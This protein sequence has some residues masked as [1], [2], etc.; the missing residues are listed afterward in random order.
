MA[1]RCLPVTLLLL[2]A[3]VLGGATALAPVCLAP[4]ADDG[5]DENCPPACARCTSCAH[6]QTV[7][8]QGET[9]G[10]FLRS[11]PRF[12]P[13]QPASACSR[14]AGDIFHVPLLG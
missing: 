3:V 1:R 10:I 8:V 6:A 5:G 12:E 13:R 9:H 4:C 2:V 7:I 11:A 14:P